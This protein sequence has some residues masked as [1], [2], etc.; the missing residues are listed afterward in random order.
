[1]SIE[2]PTVHLAIESRIENIDL[3]QIVVEEALKRLSLSEESSHQVG[4]AVREAVANAIRHGNREDPSKQVDVEFRVEDGEVV[5]AVKDEGEGFDPESIRDPVAE[6]NLMRPNGRGILF[7]KSFMDSID[8]EFVPQG[9]T[10]VTMRKRL[11]RTAD[12]TAEGG[13]EKRS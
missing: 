4:L 13:E 5:I 8:Y 3:V 9:G 1:M 6:E 10:L 12:E 2:A 11:G 7:M